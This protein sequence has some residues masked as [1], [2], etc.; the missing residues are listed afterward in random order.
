M[1][2]GKTINSVFRR[3]AEEETIRRVQTGL[4]DYPRYSE[5]LDR[6]LGPDIFQVASA[7]ARKFKWEIQP[8]GASALNLMGLSTQVP[9]QYLFH[10]DGPTREYQ[11][12]RTKLRFKR[13][14]TREMKFKQPESA[15]IV[16]GLKSL[17]PDHINDKTIA[18][19]RDWLPEAKRRQVLRDTQT[20]T[21]WVRAAIREICKEPVH[22]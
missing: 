13:V 18:K 17:G 11:I 14:A 21:Q 4:Y 6:T 2:G 22:G 12:N 9:A 15:V 1:A 10:S 19:V 16:H 7:L 3:L 8:D 20:V 5:L